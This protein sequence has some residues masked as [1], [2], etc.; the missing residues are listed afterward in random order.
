V[1]VLSAGGLMEKISIKNTVK[2]LS[3]NS[4]IP[5]FYEPLMYLIKR[6]RKRAL[7][8]LDLKKGAKVL[9]P[10]VGMGHDLPYL[11]QN[12]HIEGVDISD[13][14]LS[15][16]SLRAKKLGLQNVNLS[17]MDAE[18]LEFDDN[19]FDAAILILFLTVVF[20]PRKALSEI[21]RT[22][23]PGG[24]ILV[25]DHFIQPVPSI[26]P[27]IKAVDGILKYNFTSIARVFDDIIDGQGISIS[28][29]IPSRIPGFSIYMLCKD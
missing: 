16:A 26:S 10:G 29:K 13:V 3:F 24:E 23:K 14:M 9:I 6:E 5:F 15:A 28:E 1:T 2:L 27:L 18:R 12:I 19:T 25:L 7:S 11:P 22:L 20:N 8:L 21:V 4:F 17:L